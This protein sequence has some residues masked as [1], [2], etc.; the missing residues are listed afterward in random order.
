MRQWWAQ[1]VVR[2]DESASGGRLLQ[3]IV[4]KFA[5]EGDVWLLCRA[6]GGGGDEAETAIDVGVFFAVAFPEIFCLFGDGGDDIAQ[7]AFVSVGIDGGDADHIG[8][9]GG[10]LVFERRRGRGGGGRRCAGDFFGFCAFIE[11]C[12]FGAVVDFVGFGVF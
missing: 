10:N 6:V 8:H 7:E 4:A 9:V 1:F 2:F 11:E 5:Q 3:D 12:A